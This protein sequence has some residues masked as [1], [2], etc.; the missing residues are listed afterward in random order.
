MK[1][2]L[3][4]NDKESSLS[5]CNKQPSNITITTITTIGTNS[6]Q[7]SCY[8]AANVVDAPA[9]CSFPS[10]FPCCSSTLPLPMS[11]ASHCW[12]T[13]DTLTNANTPVVDNNTDYSSLR[14]AFTKFQNK[15]KQRHTILRQHVIPW[16]QKADT[17][18]SSSSSTGEKRGVHHIK[19][20]MTT[21]DTGMDQQSNNKMF[22]NN[23]GFWSQKANVIISG[24]QQHLAKEHRDDVSTGRIM[25]LRWWRVLMNNI[26][27]VPHTERPIYLEC[28]I[29]IM[30]RYEFIEYDKTT[31]NDYNQWCS[32]NNNNQH[33]PSAGPALDEYRH[34]LI[35]TLRYAIS[36]LN[37][38]AIY[39]NMVAFSSKVLAMCFFKIPCV[40]A[41]LLQALRVRP[42]TIKQLRSEMGHSTDDCTMHMRESLLPVFGCH[43]HALMTA[44]PRCYASVIQKSCSCK[45]APVPLTGNWIR[46]WQSDD[47][48]LFF[49][50][51]RHYHATLGSMLVRAYPSV[52]TQELHRRNMFL[53]SSPGY[54]YFAAY[55]AD[56]IN[57]LLKRQLHQ[58]T[59]VLHQQCPLTTTL[60]TGIQQQPS[61]SSVWTPTTAPTTT[62]SVENERLA[63]PVMSM[64][65]TKNDSPP[66]QQQPLSTT[67]G[68][69][70][71]VVGGKPRALEMATRKYAECMVWCATRSHGV[72][73]DMLNV[74]I[75]SIIKRVS[76]TATEAVF[77][78]L[79]FMDVVLVGLDKNKPCKEKS[80][81]S[82]VDVPFILHTIHI[83][84]AKSDHTINLLRALSFVYSH[85]AF[86]TSRAVLLD[87]LCNRILLE[88]YVFEKLL[89]HWSRNVRH[90]FWRCLFWRVGRVWSHREIK[91]SQHQDIQKGKETCDGHS[92]F[93][94]W[95]DDKTDPIPCY[96]ALVECIQGQE[97][98]AYK[99]CALEVH[100][101]LE[102]MLVSLSQQYDSDIHSENDR[103]DTLDHT[104]ES[105]TIPRF[106]SMLTRLVTE[107]ATTK[108]SIR[109]HLLAPQPSQTMTMPTSTKT[110]TNGN[111][112]SR[113]QRQ[114]GSSILRRTLFP[115]INNNTRDSNNNS[116][117]LFPF[118][119][120]S[121]DKKT[122]HQQQP[123][124]VMDGRTNSVDEWI[125]SANTPC[126]EVYT[127]SSYH[128]T[129]SDGTITSTTGSNNNSSTATITL[130]NASTPSIVSEP[131]VSSSSSS[132]LSCSSSSSSSK[133]STTRHYSDV[134]PSS[135]SPSSKLLLPLSSHQQQRLSILE[136]LGSSNNNTQQQQQ[137]HHH[138]LLLDRLS[139]ARQW[140]YATQ[141][142]VYASKTIV[143]MNS[144]MEEYTAW[145]KSRSVT[146]DE[147]KLVSYVPN[148][149]LDWPKSWN[150]P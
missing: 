116:N 91:W 13:T 34:L 147:K 139:M 132:S 45:D 126:I 88:P 61:P 95:C 107:S 134:T 1:Q 56:K 59:T 30:A 54:V 143:E 138:H 92:C 76:L 103:L 113:G 6:A 104:H 49:S 130:S 85:F 109:N 8:H 40:A 110:D 71:M 117:R 60:A 25:L 131:S 101:L 73:H 125:S 11:T 100:I 55:F 36:K 39:A 10:S 47:S 94:S 29:D 58:V 86:L 75:R 9:P 18:S 52:S 67:T 106:T 150:M 112:K 133:S 89:L 22:A 128:S 62:T 142:H 81:R 44:D 48:D 122:K 51:Y 16:L 120:I 105:Y 23:Q 123:I 114:R 17:S 50:F 87:M 127:V 137:Q 15:P 46:R 136:T 121:D 43:L 144:I 20:T 79:D 115:R 28:I 93:Q 146:H 96:E 42:H 108:K 38:K 99:R 72:F 77:C 98:K 27:H 148:L 90:F 33:H 65:I 129:S 35:G 70:Q 124:K 84:L 63:N 41:I 31:A 24:A 74:W 69:Q 119:S 83:L 118:L 97:N 102:S 64:D 26:P 5:H 32:N 12:S 141:N 135:S 2:L 145:K 3:A 78:L 19:S 14:K 66:P 140:K 68:Q 4:N 82:P 149:C 21:N 53:A 7:V 37:Q 57:S 80:T 111:N